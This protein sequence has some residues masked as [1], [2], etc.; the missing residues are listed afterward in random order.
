MRGAEDSWGLAPLSGEQE[1]E[2]EEEEEWE[3]QNKGG[4]ET[5]LRSN[6]YFSTE[7]LSSHTAVHPGD[8]ATTKKQQ[9]LNLFPQNYIF[10]IFSA[11]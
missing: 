11:M 9:L 8:S 7:C 10:D 2:E 3:E 6:K 5:P 1:E 4:G